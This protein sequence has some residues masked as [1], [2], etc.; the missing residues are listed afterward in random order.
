MSVRLVESG[1]VRL[2]DSPDVLLDR[3]QYISLDDLLADHVRDGDFFKQRKDILLKDHEGEYVA[4]RNAKILGFAKNISG[5]QAK[6]KQTVG[7]G[8][9]VFIAIIISESFEDQLPIEI[10]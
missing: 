8:D 10:F 3:P 7:Q 5:L 9:R 1:T 4:I 6:I 2:F